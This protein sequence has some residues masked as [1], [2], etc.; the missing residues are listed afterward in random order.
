M[1]FRDA[2]ELI[3]IGTSTVNEYG[4]PILSKTYTTTYADKLAITS[5]EFYQSN[6]QNLRPEYKFKIRFCDYN[7][8]TKIRYPITSGKE[9]D[10]IRTYNKGDEFIELTCQGVNVNA[11]A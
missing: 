9:F 2:I 11:N 4:D 8:Q 5:S 6:A 10:V 1:L 3:A 7:N